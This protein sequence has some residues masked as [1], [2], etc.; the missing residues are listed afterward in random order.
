MFAGF[1][2][3]KWF[4]KEKKLQGRYVVFREVKNAIKQEFLQREKGPWKIEFDLKDDDLDSTK[5][6]E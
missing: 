2:L 3:C 5:E 6:R 1:F 4:V